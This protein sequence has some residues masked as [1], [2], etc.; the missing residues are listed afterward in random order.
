MKT[1]F[2]IAVAALTLGVAAPALAQQVD[3]AAITCAEAGAMTPEA[4][5]MTIV[6]VDGYTGGEAGDTVLDFD[7]LGGDLDKV[8][9]ACAADGAVTLMDAMKAALPAE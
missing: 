6:F 4:L 9:E 3:I 5:T 7:R 2:K 1:T 8:K